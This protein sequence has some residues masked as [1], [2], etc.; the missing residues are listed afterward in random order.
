MKGDDG[1]VADGSL[2]VQGNP[3]ADRRT[4][5]DSIDH[6]LHFAVTA[7]AAFDGVGRGR[8]QRIV[9]ERQGL[10][11]LGREPLAPGF[12]EGSEATDPSP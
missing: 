2:Q 7:V 9:Q 3:A 11:H 8:Q 10:L 6:L 5:A 1:L 12:V 4:G